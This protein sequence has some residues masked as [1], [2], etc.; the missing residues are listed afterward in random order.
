MNGLMV[1][2]G[3]VVLAIGVVSFTYPELDTEFGLRLRGL[4]RREFNLAEDS[5]AVLRTKGYGGA[6]LLL[7]G[8]ILTWGFFGWSGE[9]LSAVLFFGGGLLYGVVFVLTW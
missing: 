7:G 8:T 1:V 6:T 3:L 4:R 2:T 5:K 9:T